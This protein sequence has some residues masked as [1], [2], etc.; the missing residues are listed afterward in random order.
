MFKS[1]ICIISFSDLTIDARVNR[2]IKAVVSRGSITVLALGKPNVDEVEFI[3]LDSRKTILTKIKLLL[4]LLNHSYEQYYWSQGIVKESLAK[5]NGRYFDIFIANDLDTLPLAIN[6]AKRCN[7]KVFFD[8]H[9][10]APLEFDNRWSW[11]YLHQPYREYLCGQYLRDLDIMTTVC[12][13]IAKK[14]HVEYKILPDV[15]LNTPYYQNVSYKPI[16]NSN[17]VKLIHH[18]SAS[19]ERQIEKM[20]QVIPYLENR[21]EMHFM[22]VG[23]HQYI[24]KLKKLARN[25]AP[26]RVFFHD[27]VPIEMICSKL[28]EYDVGVYLLQPLG[29]NYTYAMPNKLF[30]FIMSGLCVAIAPSIEMQKIVQHYN[31]GV[32]AKDFHPASLAA[33]I[34]AL[35]VEDINTKKSASLEAAKS[36]NAE[37]EGQKIQNI[38]SRLL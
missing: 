20:I 14:Y 12:D 8:A 27:A 36:L 24:Q 11:K 13:G 17:K 9:E 4:H 28:S 5:L 3:A 26:S 16:S 35:S 31:C 32:V 2:Q 18:G 10:Y 7:A 19:P 37:I 22:L 30:D 6:L 34:N 15:V 21:F 33:T 23:N 1:N 38:I 29:F 25:I